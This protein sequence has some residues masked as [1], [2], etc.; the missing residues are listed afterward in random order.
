MEFLFGNF[1]GV[2]LIFS[3]V[4]LDHR[5]K[6]R[7]IKAA[8]KRWQII[9]WYSFKVGRLSVLLVSHKTQE[10]ENLFNNKRGE[11]RLVCL[12]QGLHANIF[13]QLPHRSTY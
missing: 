8:E 6:V 4:P 11:N 13:F 5:I 1:G 10:D 12:F 7:K 2:V 9:H 3:L